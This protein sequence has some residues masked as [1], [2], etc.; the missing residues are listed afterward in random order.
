MLN[1]VNYSRSR[2]EG[3]PGT[4]IV[5]KGNHKDM[6]GRVVSLAIGTRTRL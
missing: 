5:G 1:D 3:K 4:L 2:R 6:I